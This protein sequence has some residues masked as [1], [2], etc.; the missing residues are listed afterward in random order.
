M[1][2][3]IIRNFPS[4]MAVK[5][6]TYNIQEVGLA[7]AL[8]RRGHECDIVLWTDKEEKDEEIRVDNGKSIMVFYRH[9]KV[10]LKNAVYENLDPLISKYDVI[11]PCE[12]NQLQSWL[13]EKKYP[14]KTVI[15]HGPYYSPFNKRYNTMCQLM[16][17]LVLPTYK[18]N[19]TKFLVKSNLAKK[20][21]KNKGIKEANITVTGVGIDLEAL[22]VGTNI[23][24][25]ELPQ[26]LKAVDQFKG[27]LRLLYIGRLELRRNIPFLFDILRKLLDR[28]CDAELIIVGN[29]NADYC[30]DA[31]DYADKQGVRKN[32]YWVKKAEQKYLSYVYQNTDVFL[33]PT[34]YEIFGMVLLEAMYFGKPVITTKNGGSE[35]LIDSGRDGIVLDGF[36]ADKWCEAVMNIK[37]NNSIGVL[38]HQKI[39]ERFTWDSLCSR[40]LTAYEDKQQI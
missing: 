16:D 20:F 31:F 40:F 24:Q 37:D 2:I 38:A 30:N 1:R 17:Y 14:K 6:N 32:I 19:N 11:Q 5:N 3:L 26:E 4:Y 23:E 27:K 36:N 10:F 28:G 12:Y 15:F 9:S 22:S 35:M 21:L 8:V 34:H 18:R 39:A 33:L 13:L 7:K 29:G 25:E